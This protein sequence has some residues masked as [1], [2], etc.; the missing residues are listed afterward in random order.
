MLFSISAFS[1]RSPL[2]LPFFFLQ[3][4]GMPIRGRSGSGQRVSFGL[5][6]GYEGGERVERKV[7][8]VL[9]GYRQGDLGRGEDR[10]DLG[11]SVALQW[12]SMA[13]V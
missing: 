4:L 12:V 1:S 10:W 11:C 8:L 2:F 6:S 7:G 3:G 13:R 9:V 5:V